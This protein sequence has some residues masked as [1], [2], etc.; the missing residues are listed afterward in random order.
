MLS[1]VLARF[2]ASVRA[3]LDNLSDEA[4]TAL[5]PVQERQHKAKTVPAMEEYI[6]AALA[7][8]V[9][10]L[11]PETHD[12]RLRALRAAHR[13]GVDVAS[14]VGTVV[15]T[16]RAVLRNPESLGAAAERYLDT[17]TL[18]RLAHAD[19]AD[20]RALARPEQ[21]NQR[22]N[23][24]LPRPAWQ[25]RKL[26]LGATGPDLFAEA[27]ASTGDARHLDV[28]ETALAALAPVPLAVHRLPNAPAGESLWYALAHQLFSLTTERNPT[29]LKNIVLKQM[30]LYYSSP[31]RREDFQRQHG[32]RVNTYLDELRSGARPGGLLELYFAAFVYTGVQVCVWVSAA[33]PPASTPLL[34]YHSRGAP[35]DRCYNLVLEEGG[36][37]FCSVSKLR[38]AGASVS[39][40]GLPETVHEYELLPGERRGRDP[41]PAHHHRPRED[42]EGDSGG[43]ARQRARR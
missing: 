34:I 25:L 33:E 28:V 4:Q 22:N 21:L 24:P 1:R 29:Q 43:P 36:S 19:D 12:E 37:G 27:L 2:K 31:K 16:M 42:D 30:T 17:L 23:G 6:D 8:V 18:L 32:V 7:Y 38:R 3:M 9:A 5:K 39:F 41:V 26:N 10:A 14:R 13:R 20:T 35:A 15:S 40:S 11:D